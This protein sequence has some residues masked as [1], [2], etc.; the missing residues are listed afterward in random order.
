MAEALRK[1]Y[2][3]TAAETRVALALADGMGVPD[4]CADHGIGLATVRSHLK[5]IFRKTET[6]GQV[7]LVVLVFKLLRAPVA[8]AGG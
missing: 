2:G 3:L 6:S 8:G 7:Q 5:S 1:D 4:I